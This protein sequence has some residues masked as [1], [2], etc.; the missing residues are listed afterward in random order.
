[1]R[2]KKAVVVGS[3]GVIGRNPIAH[4]EPQPD[5]DPVGLSRRT[6]DF[7]TRARAI[8]VDLLDPADC[9]AK[10]TGL[11]DATHAFHCAFQARPTWAGVD[12]EER[13]LG[14]L[15]EFRSRKIVP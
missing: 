5:W 7:A 9:R 13:L 3:L 14:L 1:M 4:L 15:A 6:P 12:S 2:R 10:L 11:E 8:S